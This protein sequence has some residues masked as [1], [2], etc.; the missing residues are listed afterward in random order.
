MSHFLRS[1]LLFFVVSMVATSTVWASE[2]F[3]NCAFKTGRSANLIIPAAINPTIAGQPMPEGTEIAIYTPDGVCAGRVTWQKKNVALAIWGN[4]MFTVHKD[5]MEIGDSLRFHVWHPEAEMELG[6]DNVT[7]ELDASEEYYRA[8]G[9]YTEGAI[10][11]LKS[12]TVRAPRAVSLLAPADGANLTKAAITL[13]WDAPEGVERY[14]V[15]VSNEEDFAAPV[16]DAEVDSPSLDFVADDGGTYYWRVSAT[17]HETSLWSATYSF[18]SAVS[19]NVDTDNL[20]NGFLL[21]Q[22]YPNPFNPSTTIPFQLAETNDVTLRVYNM[23]GQEVA[24]LV[25]GFLP[26]G[27]HEARWSAGDLPSGMYI[28]RLTHGRHVQSKTLTLVK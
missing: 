18:S 15:Q 7:F 16:V 6:P 24:T 20:T 25:D 23:L 27:R 14:R 10:F 9:T 13:S 26:A 1:T 22:N 19:A 28:Y 5:G 3:Q 4:D 2:H 11:R 21:E 12:L 17:D 8:S